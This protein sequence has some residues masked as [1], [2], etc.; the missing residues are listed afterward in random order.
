M[1]TIVITGGS[2][3]IGEAMARE[4][5]RR[6]YRVGLLARRHE[7]SEEVAA[8]VRQAGG[9]AIA[10]T[11]DVTDRGSVSAAVETV[12]AEFGP[13][14]VAI[15][16]A[17]ISRTIFLPR[18]NLDDAEMIFRT[19]VFGMFYLFDAT[20]PQMVER[21]RGQFVGVAS[22]AGLRALPTSSVY[23]AS[24]AAMQTFLE[25]ARLELARFDVTV[26]VVNPGF[27]ETAMTARHKFKM[28]FL[29]SSPRAGRLIVDRLEIGREEINFPLPTAMIM[30]VARLMP[31][32][33]Y[34]RAIRLAPDRSAER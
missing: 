34:A 3:G 18:L 30:K 19:N 17:G 2:S 4:Y 6:K 12:R 1:K 16:N 21:R 5:G 15:A 11:C 22:L 10:L 32:V 26:S 24:K 9:A 13:I 27:V 8:A 29:V 7:L 20:V 31:R 33:L 28:P 25:A 14:D 23:S